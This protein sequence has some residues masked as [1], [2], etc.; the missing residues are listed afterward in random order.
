MASNLLL[1]INK[2]EKKS[3]IGGGSFAK[4]FTVIDKNTK[5]I[6]AAKILRFDVNQ[7]SRDEM[8]G[9]SNEVNIMSKLNHPSIIKFIGYSPVDFKN[10]QKPVI[11][12]EYATNNSLKDII[13]LERQSASKLKWDDTK[14]LINIYG[15]ASGML[16]LH[17]H[18]IIHRDLKPDN[19]LM[20]D[21][22]NPKISDFNLSKINQSKSSNFQSNQNVKGTPHYIAPEI[23]ETQ[24]YGKECDVYSFSLIV[25]EIVTSE[26]PFSELTNIYQIYSKVVIGGYRPP[27]NFPV[28]ASYRNMIEKC[29]SYDPRDRPTFQQIV[30]SLKT[31]NGFITQ[32]VDKDEFMEY[33]ENDEL[34]KNEFYDDN[35]IVK[36]NQIDDQNENLEIST[37][38]QI[39]TEKVVEEDNEVIPTGQSDVVQRIINKENSESQFE[40]GKFFFNKAIECLLSSMENGCTEST[41]FLMK[42]VKYLDELIRDKTAT[43]QPQ[44]VDEFPHPYIEE[45]KSCYRCI[46]PLKEG[47]EASLSAP[48]PFVPYTKGT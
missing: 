13:Q 6:F 36:L 39:S 16:Y 23:W 20:D 26:I 38:D 29:W 35:Q 21:D 43:C 15:I 11:F 17:S 22:L 33:V 31:D 37:I 5:E 42:H 8:I 10:R 40:Q 18:D 30:D 12:L 41:E 44:K 47:V 3:K 4:A 46:R 19:I 9:L 27:F 32:T 24:R 45:L 25:Y 2:F 1:D 28:P 14:K 34:Y 48:G 7:I